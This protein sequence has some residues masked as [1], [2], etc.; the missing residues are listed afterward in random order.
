MTRVYLAVAL[1]LTLWGVLEYAQYRAYQK[2]QSDADAAQEAADTKGA[3]DVH[4]DA[5]EGRD[6]ALRQPDV[7]SL[8]RETGGLREDGAGRVD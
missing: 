2:G 3:D 1:I 4:D 6:S 5:S 7:D 8:L